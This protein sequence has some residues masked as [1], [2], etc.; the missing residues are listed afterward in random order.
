[1]I[2]LVDKLLIWIRLELKND[3]HSAVVDDFL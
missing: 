2:F 3:L 1:M